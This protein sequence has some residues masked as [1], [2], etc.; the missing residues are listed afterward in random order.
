MNPSY[1]INYFI[2]N[3]TVLSNVTRSEETPDEADPF[4]V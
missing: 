2:N 3:E 1:A 4:V